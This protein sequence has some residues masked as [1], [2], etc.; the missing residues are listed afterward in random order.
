LLINEQQARQQLETLRARADQEAARARTEAATAEA[1][2]RF[3]NEDLFASADPEHEPDREITLRTVLDRASQQLQTSLAQQPLVAAAIHTTIGEAYQNL[4]LYAQAEEHLRLAHQLYERERGERHEDTLRALIDFAGALSRKGQS[5]EAQPLAE[6]AHALAREEFGAKHPLTIKCA[7]ELAW[8]YY[9][10]QKTAEAY[11]LAEDAYA[12]AQGASGVN[13]GDL[14]SAMYLVGRHRGRSQG[15]EFEAG[16]KILKQALQLTREQRGENHV[17][18]V[19]VKNGLAAYYYDHAKKSD[20]AEALFLDALRTRQQLL[21]ES[22]ASTLITHINLGLL[23]QH[24]L[25]RPTQA[26]FHYVKVLEYRPA[27]K[28]ALEPLPGLFEKA[29]LKPLAA[30]GN[31]AA[32]RVTTNSPPAAWL[33]AGFEDSGW[34]PSTQP[35]AAEAWFRHEFDLAS[36]P[37]EPCLFKI[38]GSGGFEVFVNGVPAVQMGKFG[39]APR[40]FQLAVGSQASIKALRAGRNVIAIHGIN[41]RPTEELH[42]AVHPFPE[43]NLK[44]N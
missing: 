19:W 44:L 26:I 4:S 38:Q 15:G 11:Q 3:L 42:M 27:E 14:M 35:N 1:V 22:H 12:S 25:N 33:N 2:T 18:T 9:R 6:R 13:D 30:Q 37:G 24:R 40:K 36:L 10:T 5:G 43:L 28:R 31:T 7:T 8:I 39:S 20:E 16:E 41:L 34:R 23:Y 17:R 21:G 29:P 32:W